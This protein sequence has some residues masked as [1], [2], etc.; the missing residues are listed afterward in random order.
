MKQKSFNLFIT[1]N[2]LNEEPKDKAKIKQ[3]I[4]DILSLNTTN[5]KEI[6]G[7]INILMKLLDESVISEQAVETMISELKTLL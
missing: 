4:K 7:I 1:E 2:P 5:N 3:L 6:L